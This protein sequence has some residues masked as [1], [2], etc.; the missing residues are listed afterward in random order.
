[1]RK[2]RFGSGSRRRLPAL[3]EP[4]DD[5]RRSAEVMGMHALRAE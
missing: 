3:R 5:G 1:M 4:M 2:K